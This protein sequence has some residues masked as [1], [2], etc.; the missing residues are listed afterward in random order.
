MERSRGDEAAYGEQIRHKC[1]RVEQ[2]SGR[3]RPRL[4]H[5]QYGGPVRKNLGIFPL[6]CFAWRNAKAARVSFPNLVRGLLIWHTA[7][8]MNRT[9]LWCSMSSPQPSTQDPASFRHRLPHH[10]SLRLPQ[11]I[12]VVNGILCVKED[13]GRQSIRVP[14][15]YMTGFCMCAKMRALVCDIR[16]C[17]KCEGE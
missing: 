10:S 8:E 9:N 12:R 2:S 14:R 17:Q 5:I 4:L 7:S 16:T 11:R 6:A 1:H 15:Q 3:P 13:A